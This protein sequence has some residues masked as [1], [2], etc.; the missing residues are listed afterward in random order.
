MMSTK[1]LYLL[2]HAKS[3]RGD[4]KIADF[5][6][7]LAPRGRRDVPAVAAHMQARGYRPDLILCSPAKRTRETL[8]LVQPVLGGKIST[9]FDRKLYLASAE[10][11]LQRLRQVD[12]SAGSVLI[13]GHNPGLERLAAML[14]PRGDRRALARLR[15]KYPT[16]GLAAIILHVDRWEQVEPGAGALT[17]FTDPAALVDGD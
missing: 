6:R 14:A 8:A 11:M 12:E 13:I 10:A 7:P 15:E 3:D 4:P 2:R 1:T 5:D 17:D 9:A 16:S